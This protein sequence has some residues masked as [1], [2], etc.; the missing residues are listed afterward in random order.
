[1]SLENK[2]ALV[3]GGSRGIGRA[4]ALRLARDGALVAI[5]YANDD[6]AAKQTVA[7]IEHAGGKAFAVQASLGSQD[8]ADKLFRD[9]DA[10][11]LHRFDVLVN[12]AAVG[13]FRTVDQTSERDLDRILAV[14]VKGPFLVTRS[15][16]PRLADGG[17]IINISSST[18]RRPHPM[19]AAYSM[20]KAA[21]NAFTEML[22]AELG[23]RR[24]TVNTVSPG[25]TVTD[26]NAAARE[27]RQLVEEV[28]RRTALGR[29]GEPSEIA[30]VVAFLASSES[31]WLTGQH[32]EASGGYLL[33]VA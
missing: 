27:D 3:T 6:Q 12:N 13:L 18:S 25:W 2:V 15:A 23:P 11:G 7:T 28:A 29:F 9:L 5:N 33:N 16:L 10:Q 31:G 26:G 21:L 1:M 30:D 17:R 24:I 8:E 32:I 4:I 19:M 14:N 20:T 22:G